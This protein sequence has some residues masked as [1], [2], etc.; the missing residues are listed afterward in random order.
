MKESLRKKFEKEVEGVINYLVNADKLRG[1]ILSD[2]EDL[3][4]YDKWQN[5]L[6]KAYDIVVSFADK[7]GIEVD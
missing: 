4:L 5:V 7:Q 3:V 6:A 2:S 1:E